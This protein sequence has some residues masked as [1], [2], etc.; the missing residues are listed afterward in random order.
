M[1]KKKIARS[2]I[3]DYLYTWDTFENIK[4]VN[5]IYNFYKFIQYRYT[6]KMYLQFSIQI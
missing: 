6:V 1:Y 4:K 2:M 5:L 3:L